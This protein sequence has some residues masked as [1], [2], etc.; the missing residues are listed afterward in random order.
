[1]SPNPTDA[2]ITAVSCVT[3]LGAS[4]EACAAAVRAGVA[5]LA[6]SDEFDD[7]EGNAIIVSEIPPI[8]D[9]SDDEEIEDRI[10]TMCC[11]CLEQLLDK[12]FPEESSP[13]GQ[14]LIVL[15]LPPPQRPGQDF[16]GADDDLRIELLRIL[17]QR[18]ARTA[19][20]LI[21]RGNPS[22]IE[23][24]DYARNLLERQ[25][26]TVCI[27]GA[28][29]SLLDIDT[30]DWLEDAERPKSETYGRN[31]GL[32]PGEGVGL[33]MLESLQASEQRGHPVLA[34]VLGVGIADETAPFLSEAPSRAE[35]LT[36]ACR[37]A[38]SGA[39]VNGA[40][41]D[42]V[43]ADLNGEFFRS[44]EW[45]ITEIR[46]LGSNDERRLWHP[47]DCFGDLAAAS[48]ALL[49]VLGTEFLSKGVSGD[50]ALIF[51]SDDFG[52]RGAAILA[53]A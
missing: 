43:F 19:F 23:A 53:R 41:I 48:G 51:G 22:A 38:L 8:E 14:A 37:N 35:G 5:Q 40:S 7:A 44:K 29:D 15:G 10:R 26:E 4:A 33:L 2:V 21:E 50:R 24:L 27:V 45:A 36:T 30:I 49:M 11:Y 39:S 12:T 1:M 34:R 6:E 42:A 18:F 3:S 16:R 46:C 47:A 31:Q 25:P 28:C 13:Q 20:R 32:M 52:A 17:N 9:V